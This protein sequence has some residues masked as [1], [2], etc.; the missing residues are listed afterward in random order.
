[1]ILLPI[2]RTGRVAGVDGDESDIGKGWGRVEKE[3]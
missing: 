3:R 2:R 1:L